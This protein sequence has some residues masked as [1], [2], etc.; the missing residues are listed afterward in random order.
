MFDIGNQPWLTNRKFVLYMVI[1]SFDENA[2]M[3]GW[4]SFGNAVI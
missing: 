2:V 3:L 1:I 4:N